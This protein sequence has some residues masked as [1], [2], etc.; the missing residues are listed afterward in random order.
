MPPGGILA[1]TGPYANDSR[2]ACFVGEGTVKSS[3][4]ILISR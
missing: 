1:S 2:L 4:D 3:P